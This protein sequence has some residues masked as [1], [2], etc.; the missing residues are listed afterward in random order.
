MHPALDQFLDPADDDGDHEDGGTYEGAD[1]L[2]IVKDI[3]PYD[4]EYEIF[5]K[6][7]STITIKYM[8]DKG[9]GESYESLQSSDFNL[10]VT[11]RNKV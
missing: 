1:A 8:I 11:M 2:T 3:S 4:Y 7:G 10:T 5:R 9:T 6:E